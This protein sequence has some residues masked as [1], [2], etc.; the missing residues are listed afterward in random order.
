MAASRRHASVLLLLLAYPKNE[1]ENLTP[2]QTK[3]LKAI[4]DNEFP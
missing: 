3:F 4:I 1:Q 2:T